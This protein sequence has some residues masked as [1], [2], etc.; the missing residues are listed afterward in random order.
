MA[1]SNDTRD[2]RHRGAIPDGPIE[3]GPDDDRWSGLREAPDRKERRR[4]AKRRRDAWRPPSS[5]ERFKILF[6]VIGKQRN[7]VDLEDHRARYAMIFMGAINTA[8]LVVASRVAAPAALPGWLLALVLVYLAATMVFILIAV[9]C[10][11]PRA[12]PGNSL[13][14]WEGAV[15][16]SVEE[17]ERAWNEVRMLQLNREAAVIAHGLAQMI[18]QKYRANRRLYAGLPVLLVFGAVLVLVLAISSGIF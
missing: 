18:E 7:V 6:E 15:M 12:L 17:Y 3:A 9:D 1:R 13:L 8:V 11:R 4:A 5:Y 16:Q 10:L 14:H 2:L